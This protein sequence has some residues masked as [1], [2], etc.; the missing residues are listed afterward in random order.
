MN[1]PILKP[2]HRWE[3]PS[4]GLQDVTHEAR[5]H[6]R[7]HACRALA[8]F[9]VPMAQ[10]RGNELRGVVHR[11]VEREDYIGSE[12][13]QLTGEGRPVMAIHTE[14]DDGHDTHIFAPTATAG[15]D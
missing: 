8:G 11:V 9:T 7:M 14:R 1:V 6:T 15:I 10:V 12:R 4:C 13:V 2:E 5:P 3:C